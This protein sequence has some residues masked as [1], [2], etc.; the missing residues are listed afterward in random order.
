[1]IAGYPWNPDLYTA[2]CKVSPSPYEI[3]GQQKTKDLLAIERFVLQPLK[4][5]SNKP[6]F[7]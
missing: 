3:Y 5:H 1:L 2:V 7:P 4:V 6:F